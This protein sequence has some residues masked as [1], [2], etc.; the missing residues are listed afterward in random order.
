MVLEPE[1]ACT[2]FDAFAFRFWNWVLLCR[3]LT[4]PELEL[5]L[6]L[7]VLPPT[8]V[9]LIFVTCGLAAL[10]APYIPALT[11]IPAPAPAK[12]AGT[13]ACPNP[14][15]TGA[16]CPLRSAS[17]TRLVGGETESPGV[18]I[19]ATFWLVER[20]TSPT[21]I[22]AQPATNTPTMERAALRYRITPPLQSLIWFEPWHAPITSF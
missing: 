2:A 12:K 9:L 7:L 6:V 20:T 10:A 1:A 14:V 16:Y 8:L 17:N 19:M 21:L 18:E 11:A 22:C 5:V 13:G 4:L 3:V 15:A